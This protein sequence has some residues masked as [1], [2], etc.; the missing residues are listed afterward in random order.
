[1]AE[2]EPAVPQKFFAFLPH[3]ARS[4]GDVPLVTGLDPALMDPGFLGGGGI[5]RN[6]ALQ[7]ILDRRIPES[8]PRLG[9]LRFA[10]VDLSEHLDKQTGGSLDSKLMEPEFAGRN[11]TRQGGL[12]S[13]AKLAIMYAA[14]Q[15]K[16]DLEELA[17]E[18]GLTGRDEIFKAARDRWNETQ[19]PDPGKVK[20][21]HPSGP[22]IELRGQLVH[23]EGQKFPIPLPASA[24]SPD[25]ERIFSTVTAQASGGV[26]LSFEGSDRILVDAPG[27]GAPGHTS[28]GVER[29]NK[30]FHES[31]RE[32][33]TLT[34]AERLFLA[35][36]MSDN[37]AA[38]TC[39]QNVGFWYIASS[40]W[41]CGLYNPA[42]GGGLWEGASH[43]SLANPKEELVWEEKAKPPDL[44][45]QLP[46][47]PPG[48]DVQSCTAWSVAA[49]LTLLAQ[50]RLVTPESSAAMRHLMS[51]RKVGPTINNQRRRSFDSF[52]RSFFEENLAQFF[53]T[54]NERFHLD[55]VSSKLGIGNFRNDCILVVRSD[56]RHP[57]RNTRLRYVAAGFDDNARG[58]LLRELILE[59]DM[60]IQ[61]NNGL[62]PQNRR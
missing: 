51:K 10:L 6:E 43:G 13:M 30:G 59:L 28:P 3:R 45:V 12:G 37:A 55:A 15:L 35:I 19:K 56:T 17:R 46:P 52:T 25:L 54:E 8:H 26:S 2:P 7:R 44:P 20:V 18:K 24:S 62:R 34:F 16:F 38:H 29:F 32:V 9:K 39:V 49:L 22:R 50:D 48:A 60:C 23:V 41:Q 57:D 40:L 21:L 61:E 42:L 4:F 5:V 1:V 14:Y 47:V 27:P 11:E 36:D 31:L 58:A 53:P 33:R